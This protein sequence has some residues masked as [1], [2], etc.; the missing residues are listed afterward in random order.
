MFEDAIEKV[1]NFTRPVFSIMRTYGSAKILPSSSTLFFV[2][3]EGF[4]VTTKGTA[5]MIMDAS[6]IE[7][8]YLKFKEAKKQ[9]LQ[10]AEAEAADTALEELL[11]SLEKE[12]EYEEN[13]I[14]QMKIRFVDCVDALSGIQCRFHPKADVAIL[15]LD[16]F[17]QINYSGYATFAAEEQEI[18]QGKFLCRLGFPFPEFTNYMYDAQRD[19]I[20]WTN[21]GNRTSPRFPSEGMV[22][23]FIGADNQIAGIEMSTPGFTGQNGGP[24]FD[25]KGIVY[26]MQSSTGSLSF[27]HCVH[28]DVIKQFLEKEEVQYY[29]DSNQPSIK[30]EPLDL[31][32]IIAKN[33]GKLQ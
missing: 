21:E 30:L 15:K 9:L 14:T 33:T 2:N 8:K 23:R 20:A 6:A 27:G 3:E 22:T 24:L 4:A 7:E 31:S 25:A 12:Y 32:Y 5:K 1:G 17:N 16:G 18:R 29:T 10:Q 19:E 28:A 11:K 13:T 26:G